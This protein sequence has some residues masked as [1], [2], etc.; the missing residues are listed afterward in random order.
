MDA[1][2]YIKRQ[3]YLADVELDDGGTVE[4]VE[5][6][7]HGHFE[8]LAAIRKHLL[9]MVSHIGFSAPFLQYH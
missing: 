5:L 8:V 3:E 2:V 7:E 9:H 6:E 4:V 1:C